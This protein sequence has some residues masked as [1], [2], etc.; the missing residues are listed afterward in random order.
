MFLLNN[1]SELFTI[2]KD[3]CA[4]IQT[5]FN[6]SIRAFRS[7]NAREYFSAPFTTFMASKGIL[8]QSSCAYTLQQ[9]GV[10]ERKIVI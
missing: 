2:F 1:S 6:V 5:Q 7:D 4:E 10:I 9:N 3:F 8:H